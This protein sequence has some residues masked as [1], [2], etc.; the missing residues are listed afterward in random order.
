MVLAVT[1]IRTHLSVHGA[2]LALLLILAFATYRE[3]LTH[4][5]L[6]TW[7]DPFYITENPAIRGFSAENIV[8]AFTTNYRGNYAPVQILSYMLDHAVWG[9]QPF[10]FL[11]TNLLCHAVS[12]LLLYGLLLRQ[13]FWKWGAFFGC[14]LFLVHPVQV[15][16]VAWLSQRKNLLAMLFFLMSF[17]AWLCYR[18]STG[19]P[20]MAWYAVSLAAIL[21]SLL[22]KSV[23]V[24]FPLMLVMYDRLH[25]PEGENIRSH[26]EKIPYLLAALVVTG[27][28]IAFQSMESG[29]GR[30]E[31]PPAAVVVLP[32]TMLTVLAGYM[33]LLFW[34]APEILSAIYD[35]PLRTAFDAEVAIGTGLAVILVLAGIGV[36][37][38]SKSACFWYALFFL[39]L[40]PV[41]Q[42]VPLITIMNDRYLYFPMLGV[43]GLA[44]WTGGQLHNHL[45]DAAARR[46][47][48]AVSVAV[49]LALA[50]ASHLRG[51]VWK[52]AITLFGDTV[53]KVETRRQQWFML[54]DGYRAAG[55]E[56]T[57]LLCDGQ[58]MK[59]GPLDESDHI[60][61][62]RIYFDH[63]EPEKVGA[64]A[65]R[66]V[67]HK[68]WRQVG[69]LMLEEYH[70]R[71]GEGR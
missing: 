23:A 32:M 41:S 25:R 15:E 40:L 24:I 11:L 50:T 3:V 63:G 65:A 37:R 19:R 27:I 51:M 4:S 2:P 26:R 68:R 53:P 17:H 14:A 28:T 49:V 33:R 56:R 20:A 16:N 10:G 62:S 66:L 45:A 54:A 59:P 34:P 61:L 70:A 18:E 38:L 64:L 71:R 47:A 69:L 29:G 13:G 67:K 39:G 35:P 1:R 22:S 12:G 60:L 46:A 44:A 55:D 7:D 42:V 6:A 30:A 43:A 48:V 57:A 21:I 5:F 52:D 9:M 31:Y 58:A 36:Y 8:S